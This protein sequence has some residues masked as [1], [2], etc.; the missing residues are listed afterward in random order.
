MHHG[1]SLQELLESARRGPAEPSYDLRANKLLMVWIFTVLAVFI[2]MAFV[3]K[4]AV[5]DIQRV[6]E[7]LTS[8]LGGR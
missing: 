5:R 1:G 8:A 6:S 4:R 3:G 7:K 2:V